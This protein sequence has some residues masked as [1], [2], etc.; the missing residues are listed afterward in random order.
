MG[1]DVSVAWYQC[2]VTVDL[3]IQLLYNVFK[4]Y[5]NREERQMNKQLFAIVIALVMAG[6]S[7]EQKNTTETPKE[8][9]S[10]EQIEAQYAEEYKSIRDWDPDGE[11]FSDETE[12]PKPESMGSDA[13]VRLVIEDYA[14]C[15][16]VLSSFDVSVFSTALEQ[17]RARG[18]ISQNQVFQVK[19]DLLSESKR[20]RRARSILLDNIS[21]YGSPEM[22]DGFWKLY[23]DKAH[24]A[25]VQQSLLD[26]SFE[27][28]FRRTEGC[29]SLAQSTDIRY[30][31]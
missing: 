16:V 24:R 6:C 3:P 30:L 4:N 31:W 12:A 2:A 25:H 8:Q 21:R 1:S 15:E 9:A 10:Q 13:K 5:K 23:N 7:D 29:M 19:E 26:G 22:R 27:E 11:K 17:R 18:E 14:V 28:W 20:V